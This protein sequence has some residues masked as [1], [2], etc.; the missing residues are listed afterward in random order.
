[1][2][3]LRA[4]SFPIH[5]DRL[6]LS[7]TCSK[8]LG[9]TCLSILRISAGA[10]VVMS[11]TWDWSYMGRY[12]DHGFHP[13]SLYVSASS[14]LMSIDPCYTSG[15]LLDARMRTPLGYFGRPYGEI[16]RIRVILLHLP[17]SLLAE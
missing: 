17:C 13:V 1:M 11:P 9:V 8:I 6:L 10:L 7:K 4:L 2:V 14:L 3:T 12:T 5:Q 15:K 16:V